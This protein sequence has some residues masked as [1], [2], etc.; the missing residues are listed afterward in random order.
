MKYIVTRADGKPIPEDEPCFV[1]RAQDIYA[2]T[3]VNYYMDR[4]GGRVSPEMYRELDEHLHRI[5]KWQEEHGA[6]TPDM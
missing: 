6:K 1:I 4:V 3:M 5:I 2:V